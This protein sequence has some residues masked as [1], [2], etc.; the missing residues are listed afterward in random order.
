MR[1]NRRGVIPAFERIHELPRRLKTTAHHDRLL[2]DH[3]QG[4]LQQ[5][6]LVLDRR[7]RRRHCVGI[8][9][10]DRVKQCDVNQ[11]WKSCVSAPMYCLGHGQCWLALEVKLAGCASTHSC[12]CTKHM[13]ARRTCRRREARR[14]ERFAWRLSLSLVIH[15]TSTSL[16]LPFTPPTSREA[17]HTL[18]GLQ[19]HCHDSV[20]SCRH[21]CPWSY[22]YCFKP[23]MVKH[24]GVCHRKQAY[25]RS[26]VFNSISTSRPQLMY[27]RY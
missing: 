27:S 9:L 24:E 26:T 20:V 21:D 14:H 18:A 8:V 6:C 13:S 19:E 15:F 5:P 11:A 1:G 3:G 7:R 23:L 25:L 4:I 17:H 2:A 12:H 10:Y 16:I 22:S